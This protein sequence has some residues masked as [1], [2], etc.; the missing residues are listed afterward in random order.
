VIGNILDM[1]T[2]NLSQQEEAVNRHVKVP[3][4]FTIITEKE[5]TRSREGGNEMRG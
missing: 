3:S 5:K 1:S 4:T 2:C